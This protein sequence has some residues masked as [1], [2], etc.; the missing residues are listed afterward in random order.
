M[1]PIYQG[2]KALSNIFQGNKR[3]K[4][5]YIN[6]TVVYIYTEAFDFP[7]PIMD[8]ANQDGI[9]IESNREGAYR[10]FRDRANG[11]YLSR[12][13]YVTTHFPEPRQITSL[14][15]RAV[16]YE[17]D[18]DNVGRFSFQASNDNSTW[19]TLIESSN[20]YQYTN[21]WR[22]YSFENNAYYTYYRY[23][24]ISNQGGKA[25]GLASLRYHGEKE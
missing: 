25:S 21:T 3:I 16:N 5:I 17:T 2:S 23:N 20:P 12:G 14:E 6:N 11:G 9:S 10:L 15:M 1:K 18:S 22:T 24:F 7:P 13:Q 8:S 4:K 19:T